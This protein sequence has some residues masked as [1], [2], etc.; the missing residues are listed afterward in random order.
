M[1]SER[2][3]FLKARID[4]CPYNQANGI[5][6]AAVGDGYGEAEVQL[7]EGSRNIWGLPHGGL[8][9][10]LADVAVGLAA[11]SLCGGE[12]VTIS[13]NVNFLR[14]SRDGG[15]LRGTARAIRCGRRVGFFQ[16][17]VYNARGELL[18]TGQYVMRLSA[19]ERPEPDGPAP[20][21]ENQR[22]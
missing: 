19:P 20:D 4:R 18:L 2:A 9:F 12:A 11:Q 6:A 1:T 5:R 7:Q 16:A 13:A 3:S 21:M 15:T 14:S 10:S 22:G 8:L 17:E